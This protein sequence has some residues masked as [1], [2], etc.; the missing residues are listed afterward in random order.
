MRVLDANGK[1]VLIISDTHCPYHHKHWLS[2]LNAVRTK[3]LESDSLII[4]IGDEIDNHAISMHPSDVDLYS[5][6]EELEQA[7]INMQ[8]LASLF[9]SMHLCDSNH[10][11]LAV[12]NFKL[13]GLPLR[14]LKPL[15]Q[16]YGVPTTWS[17]EEDYLLKTRNGDVYVCHG[18][19]SGFD[20]LSKEV[21][22][23][24]IQGHYHG[25]FSI[26]WSNTALQQRFNMFVGCLIDRKSLAFAYGKNHIPKPIIGVGM[27]SKCGYPTLVKMELNE[28]GEWTGNLP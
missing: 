25:K 1:R 18:K 14:L 19:S 2:F 3:Y 26:A 8:D 20:K 23:S 12:R 9:P 24:A 17:W 13:H 16:I 10:G 4:H 5:A 11:S 6:G 22:C 15:D 21:G 7:C 27:L 28:K